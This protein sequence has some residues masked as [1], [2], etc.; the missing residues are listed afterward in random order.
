[1]ETS[2]FLNHKKY[3]FVLMNDNDVNIVTNFTL[4]TLLSKRAIRRGALS[5]RGGWQLSGVGQEEE[6]EERGRRAEMGG[7][8]ARKLGKLS[9]KLASIICVFVCGPSKKY[10]RKPLWRGW[11]EREED[12]DKDWQR[13]LLPGVKSVLPGLGWSLPDRE[14]PSDPPPVDPS[15]ETTPGWQ[16][17]HQPEFCPSAKVLTRRRRMHH[18]SHL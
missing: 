17:A 11:K 9:G 5:K 13:R 14:L 12:T 2:N 3:V 15:W 6:E 18:S 8:T 7:E 4:L 10:R 1:M 16:L